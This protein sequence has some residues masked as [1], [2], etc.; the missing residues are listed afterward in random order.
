MIESRRVLVQ[1]RYKSTD[2]IIAK[3]YIMIGDRF[4]ERPAS[5]GSTG[6]GNVIG[7]LPIAP[8]R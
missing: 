8:F 6:F 7:L 3:T 1:I 5:N 2:L 4:E